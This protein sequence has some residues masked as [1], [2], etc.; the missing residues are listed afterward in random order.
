MEFEFEGKKPDISTDAFVFPTATVIG[1]V[2]IGQ[3]CYIG[4]NAIL[5]GDWGYIEIG[6]GVNVQ[7]TCIIHSIPDGKTIIGDNCHIGHGAVIHQSELGNHV[8]V[9]INAVVMDF[10]KIGD[11]CII[12]SGAVV[13]RNSQYEPRS[14][15]LGV[16][17]KIVGKVTDEQNQYAWW[18]TKQYQTLPKRY[19][20]SFTQI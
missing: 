14:L 2:K 17:A 5:R 3:N 20:D 19:H 15:A 16:P 18:A 4:P 13:P 1:G 7:D 11:D 9:G 10:S 8:L 6:N 12:G